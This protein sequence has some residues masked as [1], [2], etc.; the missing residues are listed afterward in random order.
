MQ[1]LSNR[2][3]IEVETTHN[4]KVMFGDTEIYLDTSF[5]HEFRARQYGTVY[6]VSKSIK[7]I[8]KGDKIYFHHFVIKKE[9][10][11]NFVENKMVFQTIKPFV[12]AIVRDGKLKM[13]DNWVFVE[14]VKEDEE[15]CKTES[16]IWFKANPED[17]VLHGV[18]KHSNKELEEQGA[19]INDR[20]IFSKDSEYIM[21]IEGEDLM[22]M[23]NEDVLAI[24]NG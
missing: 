14:Q 4:N 8:K 24:Y 18:L 21:D 19:K 1:P 13:L 17:V 12:Y 9:N 6:A 16:G 20:I 10:K 5:E 15:D 23:R 2:I 7:D 22:R 3:W 11:V